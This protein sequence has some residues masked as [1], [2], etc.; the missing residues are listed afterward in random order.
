MKGNYRVVLELVGKYKYDFV[1]NRNIT[2]LS[3]N[4]ATGKTTLVSA[5]GQASEEIKGYNLICDVPCLAI[6][7]ISRDTLEDFLYRVKKESA[8]E[9]I[10][11]FDEECTKFCITEEFASVVLNANCYFVIV[12]RVAL[13]ELPYSIKEIYSLTEVGKYPQIKETYNT[14]EARNFSVDFCVKPDILI[15]EGQGSDCDFF[16]K[17]YGKDIVI[18]AKGNGNINSAIS[19][20]VDC[21]DKNVVVYVDGAAYGSLIDSTMAN[22]KLLDCKDWYL[23]AHESFEYDILMSKYFMRK[24][25]SRIQGYE[26][27]IDSKIFQS[28]ERYFTYLL[29]EL[30]KGSK[31]KYTKSKMPEYYL[32][33]SILNDILNSIGVLKR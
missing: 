26:D 21:E 15:I 19:D 31:M 28:W 3:G 33:N 16:N 11:F 22:L 8:N 29:S 13:K 10:L 20:L 18:A 17:V 4:S 12:T 1:I 7:V 30:S 5:I 24:F 9:C 27:N 2:I 32:G 6:P 14:L 25:K 23:I